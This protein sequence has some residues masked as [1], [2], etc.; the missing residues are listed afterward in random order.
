M[1]PDQLD[2]NSDMDGSLVSTAN[3][4]RELAN[5]RTN[6]PTSGPRTGVA[7]GERVSARRAAIERAETAAMRVVV[8]RCNRI[9]DAQATSRGGMPEVHAAAL[10]SDLACGWWGV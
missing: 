6:E 9:D 7:R 3:E 1:D 4:R 5:D 2:P 10:G 8:Y